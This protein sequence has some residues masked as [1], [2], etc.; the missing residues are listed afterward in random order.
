MSLGEVRAIR[1]PGGRVRH[2]AYDKHGRI[3]GKSHSDRNLAEEKL[4]VYRTRE[5]ARL[6]TVMRP[7]MCCQK[8]FESE[9]KHNRLCDH[10]RRKY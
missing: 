2:A 5:L 3:I 10:C 4:E 6:N 8:P 7:C 1:T 9:G